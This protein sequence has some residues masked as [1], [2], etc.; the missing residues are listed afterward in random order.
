MHHQCI[1]LFRSTIKIRQKI[2]KNPGDIVIETKG[3]MNGSSWEGRKFPRDVFARNKT[4]TKRK[5]TELFLPPSEML[6]ILFSSSFGDYFSAR[7]YSSRRRE[8]ALFF[9]TKE[10][11]GGGKRPPLNTS[12]AIVSHYPHLVRL[13]PSHLDAAFSAVRLYCSG[14]VVGL[15][16]ASYTAVLLKR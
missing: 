15:A 2:N 9:G 1:L 6:R 11:N 16:P 4:K 10:W 7:R 13:T 5:N 12:G 3:E 14:G 8:P